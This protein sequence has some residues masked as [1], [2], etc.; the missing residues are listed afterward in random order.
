MTEYK[1]RKEGR[2]II[3]INHETLDIKVLQL[4]KP[5]KSIKAYLED[6]KLAGQAVHVQTFK[7]PSYSEDWEEVEMLL[8]E[9]NFEVLEWFVSDKK[10]LLLAERLT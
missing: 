8:H 2:F 5:I 3:E 1:K 7:V 10:D 9:K 4:S 6:E